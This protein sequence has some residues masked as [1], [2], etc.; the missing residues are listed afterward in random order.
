MSL[1]N[2]QNGSTAHDADVSTTTETTTVTQEDGSIVTTKTTHVTTKHKGGELKTVQNFYT[3]QDGALSP[4]QRD[5]DFIKRNSSKRRSL[6]KE[7]YIKLHRNT[8]NRKSIEVLKGRYEAQ[9]E[10]SD[11]TTDKEQVI[12]TKDYGIGKKRTSVKSHNDA[13]VKELQSKL[14]PKLS[15]DTVESLK[16]KYS[17]S[18]FGYPNLDEV[19]LRKKPALPKKPKS[20]V[21][22][23]PPVRIST[24]SVGT[25]PVAQE[26]KTIPGHEV[27][28]RS[29]SE[30]SIEKLESFMSEFTMDPKRE[31]KEKKPRIK[32]KNDKKHSEEK[33]KT[34]KTENI[35]VADNVQNEQAFNRNSTHRHTVDNHYTKQPVKTT[36][37][38]KLQKDYT[39]S[40]INNLNETERR[41]AELHI[42][43]FNKIKATFSNPENFN[44]PTTNPYQYL[45]END[46][47]T[48]T[49]DRYIDT[50]SSS[51]TLESVDRGTYQN[52]L[53]AQAE[54]KQ[55]KEKEMRAK[56][57]DAMLLAKPA[58]SPKKHENFVETPPRAKEM[59]QNVQLVKPKAL[60]PIN[61]ER[62]LPNPYH[63][64]Q[65]GRQLDDSKISLEKNLNVDEKDYGTYIPIYNRQNNLNDV[66]YEY[67]SNKT[68]HQDQRQYSPNL[69]KSSN[70]SS[71]Q[72]S[73]SSPSFSPRSSPRSPTL[74][75]SK[76]RLPSNREKVNLQ[77]RIK[78]PIPQPK[79]STEKIIATELLK[80]KSETR[81]Q[82]ATPNPSPIPQKVVSNYEEHILYEP[83]PVTA[84]I[85]RQSPVP[86]LTRKPSDTSSVIDPFE[87]AKWHQK[88]RELAISPTLNDSSQVVTNVLVHA[89][90]E[91]KRNSIQYSSLPVTM[92][93]ASQDVM[94]MRQRP[95]TPVKKAP[96]IQSLQQSPQ[97]HEMR[98]SVE[99]YCW[100][101]I[102]KL[103]EKQD[104]E[105][106]YQLQYTPYG[107]VE[108][109][110][111][112]RRSRSVEPAQQRHS[113][114][115]TSLPREVKPNLNSR[116]YYREPI[117]ENRPIIYGEDDIYAQKNPEF[118]RNSP[119]R[120]TVS[121]T[122]NPSQKPL[123]MYEG[124]YANSG[125]V[126]YR[127]IFNRGSLNPQTQQDAQNQLLQ[128]K[129]GYVQ[130]PP[131]RRM[132]KT[133]SIGD[134]EVFLRDSQIKQM[135]EHIQKQLIKDGQ[136]SS[137]RESLMSLPRQQ[138]LP[139]PLYG[140]RTD[141]VSAQN[142]NQVKYVN[143]LTHEKI[144]NEPT[145]VTRQN[146]QNITELTKQKQENLQNIYGTKQQ[147]DQVVPMQ[148][149]RDNGSLINEPVNTSKAVALE[150]YYTNNNLVADS[151]YGSRRVV[152]SSPVT[153]VIKQVTVT[154]K[155]CDI[156]GNIHDNGK[157][158]PVSPPSPAQIQQTGVIYGQLQGNVMGR[159]PQYQSY[160]QI[161]Q[162]TN[163]VRGSRLTAS[164]NDMYKRYPIDVRRRE[165]LYEESPYGQRVTNFNPNGPL[166]PTPNEQSKM[167]LLMMRRSNSNRGYPIISDTE[168]ETS[169][170]RRI[171]N[172]N[173]A[174]G[175]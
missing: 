157:R 146:K 124:Y 63:N 9:P 127:P 165:V 132:E 37:D 33:S 92:R 74:E 107:Y 4:E 154:N 53:I 162:P 85:V 60:I 151:P 5:I 31:V 6:N 50:S 32:K 147:P 137:T 19:K 80:N 57:M 23:N 42:N 166:P 15:K 47:S 70:S 45:Q 77:P 29:S 129:N 149:V 142:N 88:Q 175:K 160:N 3:Y 76:L 128:K 139:E 79:V 39:D 72:N 98:Q 36:H 173:L 30:D 171:M 167:Q 17:P 40:T 138:N 104:Q 170:V 8:T 174:D 111:I 121:G 14:S 112:Q 52:A 118:L 106:K 144:N 135:N 172:R 93:K 114:R 148:D 78:S 159:P 133:M 119:Q 94:N 109:P 7:A 54:L 65:D 20:L 100:K 153:K 105:L 145:Y 163:F 90:P 123:Q 164:A 120:R 34:K 169:E 12:K 150:R 16:E 136:I 68:Q 113:K 55:I 96:S 2:Q 22:S 108:D 27:I 67:S 156:Y 75:G 89:D 116:I 122:I 99:L 35:V 26:L 69:T 101:E 25:V 10:D 140:S 110:I 81:K 141:S 91:M 73:P 95:V 49:I 44:K 56:Q 18:N 126:P 84:Q 83:K 168:S 125:E 103:K 152:T 21:L 38:P 13:V 102:Q 82:G 41:Y 24:V 134:D 131:Q 58:I 11:R 87:A 62:A 43:Q 155:V 59:Y 143:R 97:K 86:I 61:S 115:S 46:N 158:V 28:L 117:P 51:N 64:G 130:N 48:A 1:Q 66:V 71:T 161:V